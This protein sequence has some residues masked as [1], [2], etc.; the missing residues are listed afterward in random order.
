[1]HVILMSEIY[2]LSYVVKTL[3]VMIGQAQMT[4]SFRKTVGEKRVM[5]M[6]NDSERQRHGELVTQ[7]GI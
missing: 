3:G 2:D 7:R 5:K 4:S 1:M 6:S